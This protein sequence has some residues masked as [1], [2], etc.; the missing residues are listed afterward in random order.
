MRL[1]KSGGE[2]W[3]VEIGAEECGEDWAP[4]S[5]CG[6]ER[7]EERSEERGEE[8]GEECGEKCGEERSGLP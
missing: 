1:E 2:D 3:M 6:E 4:K 5:E 8:R 7:G